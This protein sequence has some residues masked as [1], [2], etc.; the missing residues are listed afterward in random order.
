LHFGVVAADAAAAEVALVIAD[1]LG[2]GGHILGRAAA[3]EQDEDR[4]DGS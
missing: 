1:A 3:E 4:R 2:F